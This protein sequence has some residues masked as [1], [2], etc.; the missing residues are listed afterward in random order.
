MLKKIQLKNYRSCID[1]E[2]TLQQGL[3]VL[4]GP[5][6][7][8]KTNLL[9]GLL[10]LKKLAEDYPNY[11]R[12]AEYSTFDESIIKAWFECE[13][14]TLILKAKIVLD[15]DD[16]NNDVVVSSDQSWYVKDFTGNGKRLKFPLGASSYNVYKSLLTGISRM[17]NYSIFTS[18]MEL[19]QSTD[20]LNNN[21][22]LWSAIKSISNWVTK[23]TYYSASQ[24]TNPSACPV[25]IEV[26]N[27]KRGQ[28]TGLHKF[29]FDLYKSYKE[30]Q[31]TYNEFINLVNKKGIKL[32]DGLSFK[33]IPISSINY[34]VHVGG[35]EQKKT[36]NKELII[37][38]FSI[39]NNL[40]S[41]NQL[42]EGTFKTIVLVFYLV[43]ESRSLLLLEEPEVCVH[44]G[45]LSS[46]LELALAYSEGQQIILTTHSDHVVD[47]VDPESIYI[48]K[49]SE[50]G[51]TDVDSLTNKITRKDLQALKKYL[52]TEGSLGEYWRSGAFE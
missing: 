38:Q 18:Q 50:D 44:H 35:K 43:T 46:I 24:F 42:S 25:S 4:I 9:N 51:S 37:P 40:L 30:N 16:Q 20:E 13:G 6:G 12:D 17:D 29:L 19:F 45:L 1:T 41:P 5:N 32:I 49:C 3:S 22:N 23:I 10:L 26:D 21:K 39:G 52:Q 7:S 8:G 47:Y 15:T 27:L 14:K 31:K 36:G 11:H 2:F 33:E 34:H 28:R 48:V